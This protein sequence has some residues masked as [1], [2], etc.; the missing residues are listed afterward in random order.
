MIVKTDLG[1][2]WR[3]HTIIT[4]LAS[5]RRQ[6]TFFLLVAIVAISVVLRIA[7]A[8]YYGNDF[9]DIRGGTYDQISYN[10]LARRVMLGKGFSFGQDWWP[11]ARA[12]QPT[13][14]WSFLYTIYL[15]AVYEV[16]EAS[17][18]AARLIQSVAVGVAMPVLSYL[19]GKEAFDSR[20]GLLAAVISALYLYFVTFAASLMT[21][22]FY[23][24]A[25]LLTVYVAFLLVKRNDS[26]LMPP[27][28]AGAGWWPSL[29]LGA[30]LGFSMA[31]A[32]LLRQVVA[33]YF[34]LL[35]AWLLLAS[36]RGRGF[37]LMIASVTAACIVMFISVAPA[38][39][40]NYRVFGRLSSLNT[41][42][43]FAFFWANH[44]IYGTRFEAVLDKSHGVSYQELIPQELRHLDE[45][46]LHRA[47][48]TRGLAFVFEDSMRFLKLSLSR[49]PVYFLFWPTAES[50]LASNAARVLSFTVTLPLM[51]YGLS[52]SSYFMV[53]GRVWRR[54]TGDSR[55]QIA[56]HASFD[57]RYVFMLMVFIV[58]YSAV[59]IVS[60]AN[61]RYRLPVDAFLIIFAA[62][63][64]HD[65]LLRAK[66]A[67]WPVFR[68]Y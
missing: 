23:I 57:F 63:G 5:T 28:S 59:H 21:E 26:Y 30:L 3:S 19:L 6:K 36:F 52:L 7:V 1:P 49:I 42:A 20:V 2:Y 13:A 50:S 60:W 12:E 54:R 38:A 9:A 45:A 15:V 68:R 51:V 56:G 37:K 65:L 32:L 44:P 48:L 55:L 33:V 22:S 62:Y 25:V 4:Q 8:L 47:L 43:G 35:L 41:N 18:L 11:Y 40:R 46:A 24:V 16:F 17:P 53:K 31:L 39:A 34:V 58:V 14:F 66:R 67:D 64:G 29:A 27:T 61:V 10:E